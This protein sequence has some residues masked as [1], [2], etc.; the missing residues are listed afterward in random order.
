MI[1][2]NSCVCFKKHP[3]NPQRQSPYKPGYFIK[4]KY[5]RMFI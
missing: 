2:H 5:G 3:V 1:A 4:T